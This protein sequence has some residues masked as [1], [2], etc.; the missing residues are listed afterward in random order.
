MHQ[1]GECIPLRRNRKHCYKVGTTK[2]DHNEQMK[3]NE[4]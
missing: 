1:F 3:L 4:H 2:W